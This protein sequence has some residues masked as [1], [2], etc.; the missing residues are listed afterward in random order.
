MKDNYPSL[1]T[2]TF[3]ITQKLSYQLLLCS[4][5]KGAVSGRGRRRPPRLP[6]DPIYLTAQITP[7]HMGL[8][9][10]CGPE[11]DPAY[12]AALAALA[13]LP[14]LPALAALAALPPLLR[15]QQAIVGATDLQGTRRTRHSLRPQH[16]CAA[17]RNVRIT[18]QFISLVGMYLEPKHVCC[19][20]CFAV[21]N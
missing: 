7:Q 9:Q 17:R 3:Q 12:L 11:L 18:M 20:Y 21:G 15:A 19:M 1:L 2:L 10:G 5:V 14:A 16:T 6:A 8:P 13:G 4:P